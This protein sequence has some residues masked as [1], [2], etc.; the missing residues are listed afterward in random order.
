MTEVDYTVQKVR[1][2][3]DVSKNHF[4]VQLDVKKIIASDIITGDTAFATLFVDTSDTLYVLIEADDAMTLGDV[5][6][7]VKLMN[8]EASGYVAPHRDSDYFTKRAL[9]AYSVVFPGR[10]ATEADTT[11][12]QT[13]SVYSPALVKIDRING[14][15][16]SY[17]TVSKQWRKEYD[18]LYIHQ[19]VSN[20]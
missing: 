8:L 1:A 18:E 16:H 5:I 11:Y 9:E 13:L 14:D 19:E 17:N 4:G 7:M 3:E 2:I 10:D 20:E 12:Y 15:L 6:S